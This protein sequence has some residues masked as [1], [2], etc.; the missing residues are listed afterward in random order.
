MALTDKSITSI[1]N[2]FRKNKGM[3]F[4]SE[5]VR[6]GVTPRNLYALRDTGILTEITRGLYRL[7]D[8]PPLNQPDLVTVALKIP[9]AVIGLISALA[10]YDLT[11]QIPHSVHVVLPYAAERPRMQY[12]PLTLY[13]ASG[14]AF[15]AGVTQQRVDGI[16]IRIYEP[17]KTVADCFKFRNKLG[18]GPLPRRPRSACAACSTLASL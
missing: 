9:K 8:L 15:A 4:T 3:L 14:K 18:T 13:W 1:E 16:S 5:A 7:A 11:T 6:L 12:P 2:I 10:F 17:E